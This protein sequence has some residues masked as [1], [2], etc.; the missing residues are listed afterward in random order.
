ML[1]ESGDYKINSVGKKGQ[2]SYNSPANSLH[3]EGEDGT[4]VCSMSSKVFPVADYIL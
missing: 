4:K 2:V 3:V 1:I